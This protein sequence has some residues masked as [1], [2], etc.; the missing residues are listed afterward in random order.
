MFRLQ[1][2][3]TLQLA[4]ET[5]TLL[6]KDIDGNWY[7]NEDA[8]EIYISHAELRGDPPSYWEL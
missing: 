7:T 1:K 8:E 3:Q 4:G 5:L 2:M 6:Q